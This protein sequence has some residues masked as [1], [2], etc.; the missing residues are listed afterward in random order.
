M[1]IEREKLIEILQVL[2][3]ANGDISKITLTYSVYA[4][5]NVWLSHLLQSV[6]FLRDSITQLTKEIK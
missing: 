6:G 1:K 4:S 3:K 2:T 5:E